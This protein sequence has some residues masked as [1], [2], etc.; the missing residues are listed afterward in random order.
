M[1][2]FAPLDGD[3]R[4][5]AVDQALAPIPP[6][7]VLTDQFMRPRSIR[8][9]LLARAIRVPVNRITE[10]QCGR[11]RIT[12]QTALLF[13]RYFSTSPECWMRLQM[14]YDLRAA[15]LSRSTR[16]HLLGVSPHVPLPPGHKAKG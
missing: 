10:I 9:T 8:P 5:D 1:T 6:G 7:E 16:A 2:C 14:E 12:A 15:R 13:A 4:P 11:R 3:K